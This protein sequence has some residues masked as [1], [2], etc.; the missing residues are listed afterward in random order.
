MY[1][2]ANPRSA[3]QIKPIHGKLEWELCSPDNNTAKWVGQIR[4]I[5][6]ECIGN[7]AHILLALWQQLLAPRRG[8]LSIESKVNLF[9]SSISSLSYL[10]I[11]SVFSFPNLIDRI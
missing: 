8:P 5:Q 7:A 10:E 1:L 6:K 3:P 4:G 9:F 2:S 11:L